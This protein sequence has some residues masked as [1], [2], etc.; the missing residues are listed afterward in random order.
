MG[1]TTYSKEE[2]LGILEQ[3]AADN[4]LVG[5]GKQLIAARLNL[6]AGVP[7]T[8]LEASLNQADILIGAQVIPPRGKDWRPAADTVAIAET[9]AAF[10]DGRV[11][12]G[13]CR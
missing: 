9:L 8:G 12:P 2:Q 6:A 13:A 4:G 11:G 10:N 1:A 3:P 7:G 5:M